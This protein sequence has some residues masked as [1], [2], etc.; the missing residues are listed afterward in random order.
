LTTLISTPVRVPESSEDDDGTGSIAAAERLLR[1]G[2][3]QRHRTAR[4]IDA[5]TRRAR[6][7][8]VLGAGELGPD[9]LLS[10]LLPEL[11][12]DRDVDHEKLRALVDQTAE[13]AGTPSD[14]FRLRIAQSAITGRAL[15]K[16]HADEAVDRAM[17]LLLVL[18]PA[19]QLSLWQTDEDGA[20]KCSAHAGPYPSK[21]TAT[22]ASNVL[23]ASWSGS[24]T[25]LLIG[26]TV[27][28]G[29]HPPVAIMARP[30]AGARARCDTLLHEIAPLMA[31][32]LER[33]WLADRAARAE[34]ILT[35]ASERRLSR[36]AFDLHDGALQN[37]AGVTGD[38][39]M[40]RRRLQ[41]ILPDQNQRRQ[42]LG[43]VDDLDSRLRAVDSELRDLCHSLES[44]VVP[45]ASFTRLLAEEMRAF[46]RRTDIRPGLEI[47]GDF[48]DLTESQRI[49][50]WRIIQESLSNVREHS[51]AREV[52]VSAVAADERLHVDVTDDGCGFE[53]PQ[54]LLDAAQRGRLGLVGVS[55]RVRLL[56]GTCEITSAP[57]GPTAV[58]VTLPRWRPE[59]ET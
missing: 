32:L 39:A 38:L 5:A 22:L 45:R 27:R 30:E 51:S 14:V 36:L 44:P 18:V 11:C 46:G 50:L 34:R 24:S 25:G 16:L 55:E 31:G 28:A 56:G 12:N 21:R 20:P 17:Q 49:A 7:L 43:C 23:E 4:V 47:D 1:A 59:T 54:T 26:V 35:E 15:L 6:S 48:D 40:L 3:G 41:A 42:V 9:V 52:R 37:V 2:L 8:A 57:G 29:E 53:V 58:S 10:E 19:R 33:R 13:L